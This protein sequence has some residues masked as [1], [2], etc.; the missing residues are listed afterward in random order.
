MA[1]RAISAHW[2]VSWL[3]R[4]VL[5]RCGASPMSLLPCGPRSWCNSASYHR[6]FSSPGFFA[7]VCA[8]SF[9]WCGRGGPA[10][11]AGVVTSVVSSALW[12][13]WELWQLP[14]VG[15]VCVSVCMAR[16]VC[17]HFSLFLSCLVFSSFLWSNLV[18]RI[19]ML[20]PVT[21]WHG[22]RWRGAASPSAALGRL[23][24]PVC[25]CRMEDG[26]AALPEQPVHSLGPDPKWRWS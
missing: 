4:Q 23:A 3:L 18:R 16:F 24:V 2:L 13:G 1:A 20:C 8:Q 5:R 10:G 22:P 26:A 17:F 15:A 21:S 11:V 7:C 19:L 12:V 14:E 9:V 6:L 25:H